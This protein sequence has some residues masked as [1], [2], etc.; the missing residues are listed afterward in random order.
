MLLL[1]NNRLSSVHENVATLGALTKLDLGHNALRRLLESFGALASL[2][3][4]QLQQNQL[5]NTCGQQRTAQELNTNQACGAHATAEEAYNNR[6]DA[7]VEEINLFG[8]VKAKYVRM[9]NEMDG[10]LR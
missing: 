6:K 1:S 2:T 5:L 8:E 10:Q 7:K 3:D 9:A 4:L